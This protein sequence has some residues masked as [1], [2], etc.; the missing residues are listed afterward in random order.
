[1]HT[2]SRIRVRTMVHV[3]LHN[4]STYLVHTLL[5]VHV[6]TCTYMCTSTHT[7]SRTTT[8]KVR[9]AWL[10]QQW[11]ALAAFRCSARTTNGTR[12]SSSRRQQSD[13][14]RRPQRAAHGRVAS[15]AVSVSRLHKTRFGDYTSIRSPQSAVN[16]HCK[17]RAKT[18]TPGLPVRTLPQPHA[19]GFYFRWS[20]SL[21]QPPCSRCDGQRC[22]LLNLTERTANYDRVE[23]AGDRARGRRQSRSCSRRATP[24]RRKSVG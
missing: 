12:S 9:H 1:M 21:V 7:Y 18:N 5:Q 24:R 3:Y 15:P 11:R 8:G 19:V 22:V 13:K 14:V 23:K 4:T 20:A 16:P 10:T 2:Y 6:Y 17:V